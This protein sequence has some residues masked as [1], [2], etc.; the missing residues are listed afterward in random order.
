MACLEQDNA[1]NKEMLQHV[2][3]AHAKAVAGAVAV[4]GNGAAQWLA[5]CPMKPPRSSSDFVLSVL[6]PEALKCLK[7]VECVPYLPSSE[8]PDTD[9]FRYTL[10]CL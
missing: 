4:Y 8:H 3:Q 5:S 6:Y 7:A 1:W 10:I 9:N 2:A